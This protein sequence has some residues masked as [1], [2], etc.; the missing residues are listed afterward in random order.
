MSDEIQVEPRLIPWT[1]EEQKEQDQLVQL[2]AI[3]IRFKNQVDSWAHAWGSQQWLDQ[4]TDKF[5]LDL[6]KH[7]RGEKV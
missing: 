2:R 4:L 7:I 3:K 6:V 1:K 5:I